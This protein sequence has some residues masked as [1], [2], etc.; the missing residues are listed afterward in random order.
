MSQAAIDQY[1]FALEDGSKFEVALFE[2][3]T[4]L[5]R[6]STSDCCTWTPA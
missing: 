4:L 5:S 6:G 1:R 3:R 2:H